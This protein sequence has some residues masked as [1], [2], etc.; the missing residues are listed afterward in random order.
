MISTDD[1]KDREA[2]IKDYIRSRYLIKNY[3]GQG[4][5]CYVLQVADKKTEIEHA[6]KFLNNVAYHSNPTLLEE[7]ARRLERAR[8]PHV[9]EFHDFIDG[10]ILLMEYFAGQ[11]IDLK[12]EEGTE[13]TPKKIA[14]VRNQVL[15]ALQHGH[16][17]GIIHRDVTAANILLG[18]EAKLIDYGIT[19]GLVK[20]SLKQGYICGTPGYLAPEVITK[21]MP[22]PE[23]DFYGL[24]VVLF[25]MLTKEL[26]PRNLEPLDSSWFAEKIE[27]VNAPEE[28]KYSL[29]QLVS[30][31]PELR[32]RWLTEQRHEKK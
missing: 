25:E 32:I 22:V 1:F 21:I 20:A 29:R 10:K 19:D 28:L 12:L 16:E 15:S 7:E 23:S 14:L 2:E 24:G 8:H 6:L 11:A 27:L 13:F 3:L 4:G 17:Q 26:T 9:V 18:R 31:Q 30:K 5:F